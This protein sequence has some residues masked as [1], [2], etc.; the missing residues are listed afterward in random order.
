[1]GNEIF[2]RDS[3][4]ISETIAWDIDISPKYKYPVWYLFIGG[5]LWIKKR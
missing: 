5:E 1:L 2:L 4:I 3:R